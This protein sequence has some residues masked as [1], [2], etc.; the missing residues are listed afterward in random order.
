MA[1]PTRFRTSA[2]STMAYK[3]IRVDNW[4]IFVLNRLQSF[5]SKKEYCDLT[6]RFPARN[7][8]IKVGLYFWTLFPVVF[9]T[10]LHASTMSQTIQ[11]IHGSSQI[12]PVSEGMSF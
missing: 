7:A 10:L 6:L 8:Q 9:R 3:P 1:A 5:F 12:F 11:D 4:G 2:P